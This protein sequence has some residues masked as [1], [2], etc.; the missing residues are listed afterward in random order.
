MMHE[1]TGGRTRRAT[2]LRRRHMNGCRMTDGSPCS[3]GG[4]KSEGQTGQD[5]QKMFEEA[6]QVITLMVEMRDC[7]TA[8]HQQRVSQLAGAIAEVFQMS[9]DRVWRIR[10]AGL[11]HDIGK[12]VIP[13]EILGKPGRLN[14]IESAI[15]RTHPRVGYEM[16]IQ[17][18]FAAPIADAVLQ[19][20]ERLDGSGYPAGL[21]GDQMLPEAKIL[22]V[23]DVVEAMCSHRP[24]RPA[25]GVDRAL[26]EIEAHRGI[27]YDNDVVDACLTLF[28]GRGFTFQAQPGMIRSQ[29]EEHVLVSAKSGSLARTAAR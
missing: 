13:I 25:L 11:L 29:T 10:M 18:D 20:H 23:A 8:G 19:H 2:P 3:V 28:R 4:R 14:D 9:N 17:I 22:G 7:H 12:I 1:T 16:L 24:Y 27:L 26:M 15:V 21:G 5:F 6:I